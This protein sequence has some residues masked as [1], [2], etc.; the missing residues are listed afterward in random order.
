MRVFDESMNRHLGVADRLPATDTTLDGNLLACGGFP[1][2][3]HPRAQECQTPLTGTDAKES[4]YASLLLEHYGTL[5]DDDGGSRC[6]DTDNHYNGSS[7][8]R[9]SRGRREE[10]VAKINVAAEPARLSRDLDRK[11][12]DHQEK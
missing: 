11:S 4:S 12:L 10:S 8:S 9:V 5:V 7:V 6:D 3:S 1:D 2:K